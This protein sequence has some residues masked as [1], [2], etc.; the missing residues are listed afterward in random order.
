VRVAVITVSDRGAAGAREDRSG[1][2]LAGLAEALPAE[3]VLRRV[4][5]DEPSLIR[6]AFL[7]G[8]EA[9]GAGLVVSTGGT[10]LTPRD[11]TPEAVEPLLDT[12]CPGIMEHLRRETFSRTPMAALSRGVAGRMGRALA[13]TL[14]GSPRAVAELWEALRPVVKEMMAKG[15]LA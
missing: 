14:P 6:Q 11:V 5:P 12:P 4:V 2:L 10:G 7:E 3:V 1:E 13:V 9:V 8:A 15:W